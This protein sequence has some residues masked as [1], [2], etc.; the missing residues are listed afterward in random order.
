MVLFPQMVAMG[1]MAAEFLTKAPWSCGTARSFSMKLETVEMQETR[2][3]LELDQLVSLG[4]EAREEESIR[5]EMDRAWQCT[6][7]K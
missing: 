7:A 6:T 5:K 1:K 2:P 4:T 3:V